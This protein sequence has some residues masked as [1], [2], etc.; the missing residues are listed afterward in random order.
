M[1]KNSGVSMI[2]LVITI[3]VIIILAAVAFGSST[4][5]IANA[6][7]SS[8]NNDVAEVQNAFMPQA[9][10]L[11]GNQGKEGVTRTPAQVYNFIA[12]GGTLLGA[13][14]EDHWLSRADANDIGCTQLKESAME[15]VIDYALPT[16]KVSTLGSNGVK[17]SYFVTRE[18]TVFVWPPFIHENK[19]WVN[20]STTVKDANGNDYA[21]E[22]G[23]IYPTTGE[24]TFMV[25]KTPIKLSAS[26]APA[27]NTAATTAIKGAGEATI[28][29][30][31][32]SNVSP[33][34]VESSG[35][36]TLSAQ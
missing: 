24:V 4:D 19:L 28:Y 35:L 11:E 17:C 14:G 27:D 8:F 30:I 1:R 7:F 29:Y 23:E 12:K 18:G 9:V 6:N 13:S 21:P 16:L 31:D 34:G 3:I 22:S 25:G 36:Y 15:E 26:A 2:S 5:T 10:T 32:G 20:G 33:V